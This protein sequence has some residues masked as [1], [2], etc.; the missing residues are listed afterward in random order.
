VALL[1]SRFEIIHCHRTLLP[2]NPDDILTHLRDQ[3]LENGTFR[4]STCS[5][6]PRVDRRWLRN[7]ASVQAL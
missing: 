2:P 1:D 4:A 6:T 3:M 5:G 7:E